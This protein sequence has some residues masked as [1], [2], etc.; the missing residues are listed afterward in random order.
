MWRLG[1]FP[2]VLENKLIDY[3][4]KLKLKINLLSITNILKS[5]LIKKIISILSLITI[6]TIAYASKPVTIINPPYE[7]K[8]SGLSN[9]DKI[10]LGT[11]ETH[12]QFN[13]NYPSSESSNGIG[14]PNDNTTQSI[15]FPNCSLIILFNNQVYEYCYED[16][17]FRGRP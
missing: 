1:G 5:R 11:N 9:F 10:V 4:Y 6:T 3:Q 16:G 13:E 14:N 17:Y 7:L 15:Y 8:S 2:Y 12:V